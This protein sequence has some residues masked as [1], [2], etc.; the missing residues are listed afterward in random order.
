MTR[1]LLIFAL[2]AASA[3]YTNKA[4][5]QATIPFAFTSEEDNRLIKENDSFKYYV[6]SGDTSR[7]VCIDEEGSYY[8]LLSKDGKLIAE[9]AFLSESDK[10]LQT[11]RWTERYPNGKVKITGYYLRS[12]PV[13][14]W[15]E[16][17]SRGKPKTL[18]NY[19]I[20]EDERG[21]KSSCLSGTYQEYHQNGKL[22]LNGLYVAVFAKVNDTLEI[23]DPITG[24]KTYQYGQHASYRSD[25]AGQWERYDENGD[26]E[27]KED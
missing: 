24:L 6:A 14:T 26:L 18:S 5:S 3:S 10:Y 9:G 1:S 13:G 15:Q 19:A 27:K 16:F 21:F 22:K 7:M 8:K 11:G 4:F 12:K 25:K 20:I 2:V 23:E 17:Y